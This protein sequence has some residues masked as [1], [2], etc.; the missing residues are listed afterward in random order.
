MPRHRRG[1][2]APTD[3]TRP[4]RNAASGG[5]V[6]LPLSHAGRPALA[7]DRV[8]LSFVGPSSWL[9]GHPRCDPLAAP[10][11]SEPDS[12]PRGCSP[13]P[14]EV[15]DRPSEVIVLPGFIRRNVAARNRASAPTQ[16]IPGHGRRSLV[17]LLFFPGTGP[18]DPDRCTRCQAKYRHQQEFSILAKTGSSHGPITLSSL[19]SRQQGFLQTLACSDSCRPRHTYEEWLSEFLDM[20]QRRTTPRPRLQKV[21]SVGVTS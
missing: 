1:E 19:R 17:Q 5:P 15:G 14:S 4:G 2:E 9:E 13:W 8:L 12:S 11:A 7:Y 16:L 20:S 3:Q 18:M 21:T 6:S 10:S